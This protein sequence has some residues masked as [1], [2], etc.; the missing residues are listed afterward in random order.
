[1]GP[2][3]LSWDPLGPLLG[4]LGVLLVPLGSLFASR[5]LSLCFLEPQGLIFNGFMLPKTKFSLQRGLKN[6][7]P[8]IVGASFSE[9]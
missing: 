7:A 4:S 8:T 6:D 2:L 3:G 9:N 1:M 5:G